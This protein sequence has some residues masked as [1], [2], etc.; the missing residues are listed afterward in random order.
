M[1]CSRCDHSHAAVLQITPINNALV[2]VK[3]Q[4]HPSGLLTHGRSWATLIDASRYTMASYGLSCRERGLPLKKAGPAVTAALYNRPHLQLGL[5]T[6]RAWSLP[7]QTP[8]SSMEH[9]WTETAE[10]YYHLYILQIPQ[11]VWLRF[12]APLNKWMVVVG[13]FFSAFICLHQGCSYSRSSALLQS[14]A[15]TRT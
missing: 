6:P 3:A 4:K 2:S 10:H 8:F 1:D 13:G 5:R 7:P 12:D 11:V 9:A 15:P 14:F